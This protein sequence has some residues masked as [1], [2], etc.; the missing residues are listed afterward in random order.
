MKRELGCD[1]KSLG[2]RKF[3]GVSQDIGPP[4]WG[5]F[6]GFPL[7]R[8]SEAHSPKFLAT[9]YL[10]TEATR[11]NCPAPCQELEQYM[12]HTNWSAPWLRTNLQTLTQPQGNIYPFLTRHKLGSMIHFFILGNDQPFCKGHGDSR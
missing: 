1:R 12:L 11:T 2:L 9:Y 8:H 4:N 3:T 7:I 6:H 5:S 10:D